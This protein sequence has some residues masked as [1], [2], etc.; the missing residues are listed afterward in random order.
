[1]TKHIP[2]KVT[3]LRG[4]MAFVEPV[5]PAEAPKAIAKGDWFRC[6][7]A[8]VGDEGVFLPPTPEA[9]LRDWLFA[10]FKLNPHLERT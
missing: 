4:R 5:E 7:S 6:L 3:R 10:P 1:M 2:A 9:R 8:E